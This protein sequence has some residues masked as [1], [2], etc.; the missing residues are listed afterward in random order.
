MRRWSM[1][2]SSSRFSEILKVLLGIYRHQGQCEN[3]VDGVCTAL[4]N[5][6]GSC[7][8]FWWALL[9]RKRSWLEMG[10]LDF[11]RSRITCWNTSWGHTSLE[12]KSQANLHNVYSQFY[13]GFYRILPSS[14]PHTSS[15][16]KR[17][18]ERHHQKAWLY[19]NQNERRKVIDWSAQ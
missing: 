12:T 4:L 7:F 9:T 18:W 10:A 2:Y 14:S 16:S 6:R 11:R 13:D 8:I 1:F 3:N 15:Q 19:Y 5:F 17:S